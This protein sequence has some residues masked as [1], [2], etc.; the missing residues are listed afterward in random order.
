MTVLI[1]YVLSFL[2]DLSSEQEAAAN[3][4]KEVEQEELLFTEVRMKNLEHF[5]MQF[6]NFLQ[7]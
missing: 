7:N 3:T 2:N 6:S 1:S 4:G 5:G